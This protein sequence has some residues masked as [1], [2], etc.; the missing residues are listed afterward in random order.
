MKNHDGSELPST[1]REYSTLFSTV[2][3]QIAPG[4][5]I[6]TDETVVG[7]CNQQL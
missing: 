4:H 3:L 2:Q 7:M 1:Q 6:M 5:Q